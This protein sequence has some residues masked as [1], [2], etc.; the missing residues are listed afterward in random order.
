MKSTTFSA[1][2]AALL[3][4]S[5]HAAIT[6][7]TISTASCPGTPSEVKTF[8]VV[9]NA[10]GVVKIDAPS[11]CGLALTSSATLPL[12]SIS[13]QA[14]LDAA[15]TQRGSALFT[16]TKPALISTTPV[17][18]QSVW[19]RTAEFAASPS[20]SEAASKT[21]SLSKGTQS[22][23]L[24]AP[25][26]V[27]QTATARLAVPTGNATVTVP[28]GGGSVGGNVTTFTGGAEGKMVG[29]GAGLV[30]V[31]GLMALVL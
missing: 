24:G 9:V 5:A 16:S 14:F 30:G 8:D 31:A 21:G 18:I 11:I 2:L 25:I 19:C 15:G 29:A 23:T 10:V 7:V 26:G 6:T 12:T 20:S 4:T 17:G 13:C 28:G 1:A 27:S 3:A 22:V